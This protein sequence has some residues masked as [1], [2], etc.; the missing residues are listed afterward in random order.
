[1]ALFGAFS[2]SQPIMYD[3]VMNI[4]YIGKAE[5]CY[6]NCSAMLLASIGEDVAPSKIEVMTGMGVGAFK[7]RDSNILFFD[8][9]HTDMGVSIAL[10]SLGF[11][12]DEAASVSPDELPF[13]ELRTILE[14]GPA[15]LGPVDIGLLTYRPRSRGANGS[16][17]YVLAHGIDDERIYLHDPWGYPFVNISHE[18]LKEAWEARLISKQGYYRRWSNPVRA[19]TPSDDK[20]YDRALRTYKDVY[21]KG[22]AEYR[23]NGHLTGPEA[24]REV[25]A[26]ARDK[27]LT[28]D[29]IYNLAGFSL[30]LGSKRALDHAAFFKGRDDSVSELKYDMAKLFGSAQSNLMGGDDSGFSDALEK[31]AELEAKVEQILG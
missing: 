26:T 28:D 16:V 1:M 18:D 21:G 9:W 14:H 11:E 15:I 7:G 24:I 17:H 27:G 30:P 3:W 23:E 2:I 31:L 20:L 12:F 4:P 5:Y 25:A 29:E 8:C 13:D 22:Q 10:T 19:E 6:S